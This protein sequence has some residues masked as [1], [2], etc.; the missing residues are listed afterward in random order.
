VSVTLTV[1][2]LAPGIGAEVDGIDLTNELSTGVV[3]QL[4][5]ALLE[6]QVLFFRRQPLTPP[7]QARFAEYFAPVVIPFAFTTGTEHPAVNIIDQVS[8]KGEFTERW[9]TDSTHLPEPP[10]G[11]ILRSVQPPPEGG[12]TAWVSMYGV[13]DGLS[14][15]LQG[16]V[17]GLTATHSTAILDAPM[18]EIGVSHRNDQPGAFA[19]HPLVRVHPET[20]RKLIFVNRNFTTHINELTEAESRS[21]LDLLFAQIESCPAQI[22][23]HWDA[24]SVALW[25]ERCTQHKAIADYTGR[26]VMQRC[27]M[28][29][30]RPVGVGPAQHG[31]Q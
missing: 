10:F 3:Q 7:D 2:G 6:H 23:F 17:D 31:R 26:R 18:N 11:A 5:E 9:H 19:V 16:F 14:P 30:D 21:V 27:M 20:G 22:R 28:R 24:D 8:P 12:D 29:G 25:D 15:A 4:R 1:H 13:Y